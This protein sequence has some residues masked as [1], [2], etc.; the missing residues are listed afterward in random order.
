MTK[1]SKFLF[2]FF[3]LNQTNMN[4]QNLERSFKIW[5]VASAITIILLVQFGHASS[6][7]QTENLSP[8]I[9]SSFNLSALINEYTTLMRILVYYFYDHD[10]TWIG[11]KSI[12]CKIE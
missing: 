11:G 7:L 8:V 5:V 6:K 1:V 9:L 10:S 4:L 3:F 12:G 2:S